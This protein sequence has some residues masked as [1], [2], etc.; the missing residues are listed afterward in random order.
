[1]FAALYAFAGGAAAQE[2][3]VH[4]EVRTD[5]RFTFID[6][7]LHGAQPG[8]FEMENLVTWSRGTRFDHGLDRFDFKH[9]IEFGLSKDIVAAIDLV[10]WHTSEETGDW[11]TKYDSTGGEL[12]FRLA[13]PRETLGAAFKTEVGVG[14]EAI[15]WANEL[16]LDKWIGRWVVAYNFRIDAGWQGDRSWHFEDS[17]VAVEQ[18]LGASYEINPRLCVGGELLYELPPKWS[19]GDRQNFFIGPNLAFRGEGW[20]LTSTALFLADGEQDEPLFQLRVLFEFE[21]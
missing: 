5:R 6:E 3:A 13:D 15:E 2:P 4:P 21:F 12:R 19:W 20:A 11:V 10:E 18:A 16:I 14:P 1:M 7:S 17:E 8:E 9:E